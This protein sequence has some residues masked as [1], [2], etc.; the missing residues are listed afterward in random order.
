MLDDSRSL[1]TASRMACSSGGVEF[2]AWECR[3]FITSLM[4]DCSVC[5][6]S[7]T[8]EEHDEEGLLIED[9]GTFVG[10]G[11]CDC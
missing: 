3:Q 7:E 11:D 9:R 10:R 1:N 6:V 2:E 4:Y 5:G 8:E